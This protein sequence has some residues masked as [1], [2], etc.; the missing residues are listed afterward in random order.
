MDRNNGSYLA[1]GAAAALAA[2]AI[3][4]QRKGGRN[5]DEVEPLQVMSRGPERAL[6]AMGQE[7]MPTKKWRELMA[8]RGVAAEQMALR[9]FED[10]ER[11]VEAQGKKSLSRSEVLDWF[12]KNPMQLKEI[13]RGLPPESSI[14][15]E[16]RSQLKRRKTLQGQIRKALDGLATGPEI[17]TAIG[18]AMMNFPSAI[19][20]AGS[21]VDGPEVIKQ[22]GGHTLAYS[23]DLVSG[24]KWGVYFDGKEYLSDKP[25][26]LGDI[27]IVKG[28]PV[29]ATM[30]WRCLLVNGEEFRFE[31]GI[32]KLLE[33]P[34]SNGRT[35]DQ[36]YS[37]SLAVSPDGKIVAI[38]TNL[39]RIFFWSV[40][41]KKVIGEYI[42]DEGS[43]GFNIT[44]LAWGEKGLFY[45]DQAGRVRLLSVDAKGK[46]KEVQTLREGLHAFMDKAKGEVD[47]S[48]K[49]EAFESDT[50]A[51]EALVLSPDQQTLAAVSTADGVTLYAMA[52]MT[53]IVTAGRGKGLQAGSWLDRNDKFM[54][55]GDRELAEIGVDGSFFLG[56]SDT[57][58]GGRG[59]FL[60]DKTSLLASCDVKT[61]RLVRIVE[62]TPLY[63]KIK[64]YLSIPH[65]E[66]DAK[67]A[68]MI[69]GKP[70]AYREMMLQYKPEQLIQGPVAHWP[71]RNA[72]GWARMTWRK[73][74]SNSGYVL[75][76]DEIQSDWAQRSRRNPA[77]YAKFP[78]PNDW[79][80]AIFKHALVEA[81]RTGATSIALTDAET[82]GPR[83]HSRDWR[84]ELAPF[85]DVQILNWMK[86]FGASLG[87][88]VK[89][90]AIPGMTHDSYWGFD[91]TPENVSKI[92]RAG[93]SLF[94]AREGSETTPAASLAPPK[95]K[96][97]A[98][99][100]VVGLEWS[101]K[102]PSEVGA[103][104]V[105]DLKSGALFKVGI[106][107]DDQSRRRPLPI[108]SVITYAYRDMTQNGVP[109]GA[110]FVSDRESM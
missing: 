9:G 60:G 71:E 57:L 82:I 40:K 65:S 35:A 25:T 69:D 77:G 55:I 107:I 46:A 84:K 41:D 36:F 47:Q 28:K 81:I 8:S 101:T 63:S 78:M 34:N 72:F 39:Y 44:A 87:I 5:E 30:S 92:K 102:N 74:A 27:Q 37:S 75:F 42:N 33:I 21:K 12:R 108:G 1:I 67:Y 14:S 13:W 54:A 15:E 86:K 50:A 94:G 49:Q 109:R 68:T 89:R 64:E 22:K 99:A 48:R 2:V 85:Y 31:D 96:R 18:G 11:S 10:F 19:I 23:Y 97:D 95:E 104:K 45:A 56:S 4:R 66:S 61:I 43:I 7:K 53:E 20:F 73:P 59:I 103:Y 106:R 105:K 6:S 24:D 3:I 91:L 52:A 26:R 100:E 83:V 62:G 79:W 80:A 16:E 32:L 110:T 98:R 90:I 93:L 58:E 76:V 29:W 88:E 17:D 38:G 70:E 51:V